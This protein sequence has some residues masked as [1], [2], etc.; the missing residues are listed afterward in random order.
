MNNFTPVA[1][2]ED[3]PQGNRKRIE[4]DGK[5]ISIFNIDGE[6]YAIY[7]TCP[8]KG[9]APLIRG[10]LDGVGIKCPNHGYRFD[11]KTGA[12]NIDPAFNAKV[13]PLKIKDGN[14][15]LDLE[16]PAGD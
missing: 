16:N 15:L 9:T 3:I 10:T 13:Y 12:C 14:I 5:R 11:L 1:R 6:Y 2:E 8:H 4:V 7:D